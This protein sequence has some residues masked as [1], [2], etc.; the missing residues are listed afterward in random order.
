VKRPKEKLRPGAINPD[1]YEEGSA[2]QAEE[3]AERVWQGQHGYSPARKTV[4]VWSDGRS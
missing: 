3:I 4:I 1:A 2:K